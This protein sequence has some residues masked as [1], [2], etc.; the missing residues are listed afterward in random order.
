MTRHAPTH[1]S[2][3]I[4]AREKCPTCDGLGEVRKQDLLVP[5]NTRFGWAISSETCPTCLGTGRK[6]E[7]SDPWAG[8]H[9]AENCT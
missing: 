3:T 6:R 7:L 4:P 1:E 5:G 8:A 9:P 2:K